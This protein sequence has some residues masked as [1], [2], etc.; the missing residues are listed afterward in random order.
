[1]AKNRLNIILGVDVGQLQSQLNKAKRS[2]NKFSRDVGRVGSTLTQNISGPIAA[3]GGVSVKVFADFELG[4]AK[5]KAVSGATGKAFADLKDS[6]LELGR[7]TQFTASQVA[8]L[9]LNLSKLGFSPKEIEQSTAAILDLALA[10]GEDLAQSATVAASTLRGF[11]L[12]A[13]EMLRVSNVMA[14]SFS[15]TALD[16]QKFGDAMAYVAPVATQAGASMEQTTA[17]LGTLVNRGVDASS[18]GAALRNIFLDLADK[19]L[20]WNEAMEKVRGSTNPLSTSMEL[21]GKRG[22]TVATIIANNREEITGLT[23]DFIDSEEEARRMAEIME[24]TLSGSFEKLKSAAEGAAISLGEILA[25][26]IRKAADQLNELVT[27]FNELSPETKSAIIRFA[28]IAAAIGPLLLGIAG[29]AQ[30]IVFIGTGLAALA[31]PAGL[32]IAVF[33]AIGLAASNLIKRFGGVDKALIFFRAKV[34][35]FVAATKAAV[36]GLVETLISPLKA[37]KQASSGDFKTA[38]NTLKGDG[39]SLAENISDVYN[40]TL[41]NSLREGAKR[42]FAN[43][44]RREL[45]SGADG[46]EDVLKSKIDSIQGL[47]N[48]EGDLTPNLSDGGGDGDKGGDKKEKKEIELDETIY[49]VGKIDIEDTDLLNIDETVVIGALPEANI[50]LD[51]YRAG[52]EKATE[53]AQL[54]GASAGEVLQEKLNYTKQSIQSLLDEGYTPQSEA[55]QTL[56]EQYNSLGS[57]LDILNEKQGLFAQQMQTVSNTVGNILTSAFDGFFQVIEEGGKNAFEGFVQGAK[58]ALV[59]LVKQL[60]I[61]LAKAVAV[62]AVMSI[63]FPGSTAAAG[64]GFK[65]IFG[66]VFSGIPLAT[67]GIIP[68]GYPNDTFPARLSSGE[69][70]IP[71]DKLNRYTGANGG[72]LEA[73]ISGEDLLIL[74]KQTETKYNRFS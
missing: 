20:T 73:R 46:V 25:P 14:D 8:G 17:V 43:E 53:A 26:Y 32:V 39:K 58:K 47:L 11:G 33:V 56:M 52:L 57:E 65:A 45:A 67:G 63:I 30:G 60:T 70:V 22:A 55:V 24:N 74:M 3:L 42:M 21:F 35:A 64:A 72:T 18:A 29:L 13:T 66:S 15:S 49:S 37:L 41:K 68:P 40:E 9:Q 1:M 34:D 2:L 10:T 19:G 38:L 23:A 71:L 28:G 36:N 16:L 59:N 7:T 12:D 27:R 4:M 50:A 48:M 51:Q 44:Y 61:T 6:A 54:F 31:G 5:V 69:A 62:A